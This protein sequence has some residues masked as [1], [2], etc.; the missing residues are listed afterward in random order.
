MP[1]TYEFKDS[2][3]ADTVAKVLLFVA[4]Y[5]KKQALVKFAESSV[6]VI[7]GG[8]PKTYYIHAE[9]TNLGMFVDRYHKR[10]IVSDHCSVVQVDPTLLGRT[11][12]GSSTNRNI[13]L[14]IMRPNKIQVIVEYDD[15]GT[16]MI[17]HTIPCDMKTK[18][19]YELMLIDRIE[20]RLCRYNTRSY[21]EGIVRLKHIID[22]IVKLGT[23]RVYIVAKQTT[24]STSLKIAA[25]S[26]GAII[27][28]FLTG[29]EDGHDEL[30]MKEEYDENEYHQNQSRR[31][32]AGVQVDPKK[33][34]L[35]LAGLVQ[36]KKDK[37]SKI[38]FDIEHNKC[39]KITMNFEDKLG[40]K[41]HQSLLLLHSLN[42]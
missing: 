26:D 32:V 5:S 39:L 2:R 42:N 23:A 33:L 28:V 34:A 38:S 10:H 17:T 30:M 24:T 6:G 12:K 29:L 21:L 8:S 19:D 11:L 16:R 3:A 41:M 15:N 9:A 7:W 37:P 36:P 31:D 40:E 14:T 27:D 22:S 13:K 1:F 18:E 20:S 25:K 35:F 4:K